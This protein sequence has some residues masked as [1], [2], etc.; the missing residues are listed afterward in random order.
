M[1]FSLNT[2]SMLGCLGVKVIFVSEME[3][4]AFVGVVR[5]TFLYDEFSPDSGSQAAL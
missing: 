4:S 1:V 3:K 2:F 5:D